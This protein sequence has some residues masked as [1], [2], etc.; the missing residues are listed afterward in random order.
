VRI[1]ARPGRRSTS[2]ESSRSAS[3][4]PSAAEIASLPRR[5]VTDASG[6]ATDVDASSS[7]IDAASPAAQAARNGANAARP[8]RGGPAGDGQVKISLVSRPGCSIASRYPVS[9]AM[10]CAT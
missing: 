7:D 5:L 10:L 3:T 4:W 1:A 6:S 9:P 2:A 8:A